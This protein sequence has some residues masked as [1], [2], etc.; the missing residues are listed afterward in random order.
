MTCISISTKL[1]LQIHFEF[2]KT[3]HLCG[4]VIVMYLLA[5]WR[6]LR[7]LLLSC[8]TSQWQVTEEHMGHS[9]GDVRSRAVW[10]LCRLHRRAHQGLPV[11]RVFT[12]RQGERSALP[13]STYRCVIRT[14]NTCT[15]TI[16]A[17]T[18]LLL[19][20]LQLVFIYACFQ[21]A[22]LWICFKLITIGLLFGEFQW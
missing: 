10:L 15:N 22:S 9:G 11:W 2:R 18:L 1:N 7:C 17:H 8:S 16:N 14:I 21:G 19:Y 3:T 12:S 13:C 6:V 20:L 5:A 4:G